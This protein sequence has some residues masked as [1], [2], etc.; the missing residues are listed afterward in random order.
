ML[1]IPPTFCFSRVEFH[2]SPLLCVSMCPRSVAQSCPALC[3]PMD[4]SLLGSSIHGISKA[5]ILEREVGGGIRMGNT[6]KPMAVSFQCMTKFTTNKKKKRKKKK[7]KK[8]YWS[9]LPYSPP[10][11]FPNFHEWNPYLL[12]L[13]YRGILYQ[14]ATW[15]APSSTTVALN[16]VFFACLTLSDEILI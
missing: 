4:C 10:G 12:H 11:V 13:Q 16:K 7:K 5:R 14:Q 3:D 15:G 2:L 6:C 1:K 9:G 8:E